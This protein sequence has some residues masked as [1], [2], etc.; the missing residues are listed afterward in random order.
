MSKRLTTKQMT[1]IYGGDIAVAERSEMTNGLDIVLR[2]AA[3]RRRHAKNPAVER[4]RMEKW[5][6]DQIAK[7]R[8]AGVFTLTVV[9]AEILMDRNAGNRPIANANLNALHR[10]NVEGRFMDNGE[11]I[12][13]SE[14]G[15]LLDG[16]HRCRMVIETGIPIESTFSFGVKSAARQTIDIGKSRSAANLLHFEGVEVKGVDTVASLILQWKTHGK[17][18][19]AS[20]GRPTKTQI[21]AA[22]REFKG[23]AD[24]IEFCNRKRAAQ[25]APKTLLAFCHWAFAERAGRVAA[26][27][28]MQRL[29]DGDR[30]KSGDPVLYARD[31]LTAIQGWTWPQ[32]RASL[33]FQAWNYWRRGEKIE[34]IKVNE[35]A[36]PDVEG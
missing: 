4:Q 1:D 33:I 8:H 36:L 14:T 30:P 7:G 20:A 19:K 3:A 13:I 16:Q 22:Y 32:T 35:T 11:S 31:R 15:V 6:A 25:V 26:D 23:I 12:I 21:V 10:D 28:F 2:G 34:R 29:I 24:S 9:L 18:L 5:L 17:L 27:M